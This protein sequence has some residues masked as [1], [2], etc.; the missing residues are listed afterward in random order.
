ML[1]RLLA[2]ATAAA[3][4]AFVAYVVVGGFLAWRWPRTIWL[5]LIAFGWGFGTVLVGY[6][7]PLTYVENWARR[8]AGQEGLPASGFIDHYLT[9]VIYP[10][11]ALGLV[12]A[13]VAA[14]VLVS[15]VGYVRRLRGSR[16]AV[17][18]AR[19]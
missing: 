6:D 18:S 2:D 17:G 11:S 9:G 13:L 16:T 10:E 15:W 19:R 8:E 1:Y 14:C 12:R 7:C 3:H 5:H 4:F